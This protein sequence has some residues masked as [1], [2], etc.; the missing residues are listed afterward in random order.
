MKNLR[1]KVLTMFVSLSLCPAWVFAQYPSFGRVVKEDAQ[2]DKLISV[3]A[4]LEVLA[5]GF[6]WAE[7][8]VWN[9][10]HSSILF[11]DV[12]KNTIYQWT[13][14]DG[15]SVFLNPS[16]Y[17]GVGKYSDEPGANGLAI[18]EGYLYAC[19]HGDRR[20]SRMSLDKGGKE[21]VSDRYNGKRLNSPNDLAIHPRS[22][23]VYFTDPPYGLAAKAEDPTREVRAFGVYRVNESGTTELLV[24]NL[25]RPNGIAFSPDGS[26]MYVAVSDPQ[27]AYI[28]SYPLLTNGK[29]GEG[30]ILFDATPLVAQ[31]LPGLPD[32]LKIDRDGNIWT[33]GPGGLLILSPAGKLLGRIETGRPTANCAW[34]EDGSTLYITAHNYLCRIRTLTKGANY[35]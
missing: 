5:G 31:K 7:G 32:G 14:K 15:I 34:G 23:Q 35:K 12:P 11:T 18:E 6:V 10:K 29:V 22:K 3:D 26:I 16:G 17:T 27:K 2:L 8:P 13:E 33:T 24:D 9:A 21:T 4:K 19:E 20:V 28:M 25:T 30:R 1:C